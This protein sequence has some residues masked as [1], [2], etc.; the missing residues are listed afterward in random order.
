TDRGGSGGGLE[1]TALLA[2]ANDDGQT[3]AFLSTGLNTAIHAGSL[4]VEADGSL[5]SDSQSFALGIALI[6]VSDAIAHSTAGSNNPDEQSVAAYI[7]LAPGLDPASSN[8]VMTS[9]GAI[10]VTANETPHASA[11]ATGVDAGAIA[12]DAVSSDANVIGTTQ[13]TLGDGITF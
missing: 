6:T 7:A 1:V 9:T 12:V 13:A 8:A 5:A 10:T 3:H 2:T 11:A 4:N